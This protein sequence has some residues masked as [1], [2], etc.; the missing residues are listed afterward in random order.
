MIKL[1][2]ISSTDA[3]LTEVLKIPNSS[4]DE[5]IFKIPVTKECFMVRLGLPPGPFCQPSG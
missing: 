2:Q 4:S 1:V 3:I 5:M